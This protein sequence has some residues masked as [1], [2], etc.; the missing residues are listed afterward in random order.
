MSTFFFLPSAAVISSLQFRASFLLNWV[1]AI[2][3]GKI[4]LSYEFII[5][6]PRGAQLPLGASLTKFVAQ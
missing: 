1:L 5:F 6:S 3:S 2:V 4:L